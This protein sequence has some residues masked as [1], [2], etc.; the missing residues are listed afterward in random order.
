MDDPRVPR[1]PNLCRLRAYSAET[2]AD[3]T[4]LL[5]EQARNTE[6]FAPRGVD[7]NYG[8]IFHIVMILTR[9]DASGMGAQ[10]VFLQLYPLQH[11]VGMPLWDARLRPFL[12]TVTAGHEECFRIHTT[13][14]GRIK[15]HQVG[16]NELQS[17]ADFE[18]MNAQIGAHLQGCDGEDCVRGHRIGKEYA[19]TAEPSSTSASRQANAHGHVTAEI[20]TN[21]ETGGGGSCLQYDLVSIM[22]KQEEKRRLTL[23]ERDSYKEKPTPSDHDP[24]ILI[25][26]IADA[27]RRSHMS[28]CLQDNRIEAGPLGSVIVPA[29]T[30]Y[31]VWIFVPGD[32]LLRRQHEDRDAIALG[33]HDAAAGCEADEERSAAAVVGCQEI[34]L[35]VLSFALWGDGI[36]GDA[37]PAFRHSRGEAQH[38][39][40][41]GVKSD[42]TFGEYMLFEE[43]PRRC[44]EE[45][46]PILTDRVFKVWIFRRPVSDSEISNPFPDR[47]RELALR[48]YLQQQQKFYR[49]ITPGSFIAVDEDL[50]I[51]A[52]RFVIA[53]DFTPAE[54]VEYGML[55]E[56]DLE[57]IRDAD[58][59]VIAEKLL[60]LQDTDFELFY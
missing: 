59:H 42:P 3:L 19:T 24:Y 23:F 31:S 8:E 52:F 50:Q 47:V 33:V 36:D 49:V 28:L 58:G 37:F 53:T 16:L 18:Q 14:A 38:G 39:V 11:V 51:A 34:D 9:E 6:L 26:T 32:M 21:L 35:D 1:E 44:F 57:E 17:L 55:C 25:M 41:Q 54:V 45:D 22:E 30:N 20:R 12:S 48:Q 56:E 10:F 40:F 60:A 7:G 43:Y 46:P 2:G 13:P 29:G 4:F 27:S 5:S 15:G